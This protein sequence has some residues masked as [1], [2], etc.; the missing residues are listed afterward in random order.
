M[1]HEKVEGVP[2]GQH[3]LVT[4]LMKGVY[5]LRPP[6][7]RYT[8][9]WDV[10]MVI[11][12][13]AGVGENANLPLR[14]LSQ[15]LALLMAL[16]VASRTS[17]R[18][19]LDLRFRF[20]RPDGVLFHLAGITKTQRAGLPPK[21]HFLDAFSDAFV[22]WNASKI[23]KIGRLSTEIHSRRDPAPIPITKYGRPFKPVTSHRIAHWIKDI[24]LEAGVDTRVFK[25][26]SVRGASVSAAKNKGVGIPDI[27]DMV[28]WSRDTKFRKFYYRTMTS[29]KISSVF[30]MESE[31]KF[32]I[33]PRMRQKDWSRVATLQP[34]LLFAAGRL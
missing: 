22:W 11:Q 29:N 23:M 15:K 8:Y 10:D 16:S 2:V 30:W 34:F 4:L 3:P 20:Y 18:Q 27:L 19:A 6:K 17:E 33:V 24:L 5:N 9:T 31:W 21:E 7:T 25:A 1:T 26:Y 28:D 12:Y 32:H 14:K 13:T